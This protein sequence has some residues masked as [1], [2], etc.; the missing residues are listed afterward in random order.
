MPTQPS[1]APEQAQ[2]IYV[3]VRC[4]QRCC[5]DH[6]KLAFVP[7]N[8]PVDGYRHWS[9]CPNVAQPILMQIWAD[10]ETT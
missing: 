4:C 9:T 5:K 3:D 6:L 1:A 10:K 2:A 7:L 8:N